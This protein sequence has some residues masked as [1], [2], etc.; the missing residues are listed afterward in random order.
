MTAVRWTE[1]DLERIRGRVSSLADK[2]E[3]VILAARQPIRLPGMDPRMNKT[4]AAYA[5][6][7]EAQRM[8]GE[9][10]S[11]RFEAIKLRLAGRTHYTPDFFVLG[12]GGE[13]SFHEVKGYWEEDARVK[14]KVA[15][16]IFPWFNFIAVTK[17][18]KKQGGGW[19]R[20]PARS[21]T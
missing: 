5:L 17:A 10:A 12:I 16:E 14:F 6:V 15:A 3:E 20:T 9:I 4:E 19:I 11:W 1:K 2:T 8:A 21:W 18:M 13:L 7:L